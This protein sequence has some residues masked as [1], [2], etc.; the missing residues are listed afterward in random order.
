M[1]VCHCRGQDADQGHLAAHGGGADG[2]GGPPGHPLAAGRGHAP[3]QG[4][5][6]PEQRVHAVQG[7][8]AGPQVLQNNIKHNIPF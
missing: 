5:R 2:A 6:G 4:V 3:G 8:D 1:M 7:R